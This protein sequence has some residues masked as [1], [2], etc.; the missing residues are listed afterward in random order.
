MAVRALA[1]LLE[2]RRP[3][4][5]V[6]LPCPISRFVH[7]MIFLFSLYFLFPPSQLNKAGIRVTGPPSADAAL[8]TQH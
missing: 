1:T 6:C 5:A 3:V 8:G 7:P 4:F 2:S